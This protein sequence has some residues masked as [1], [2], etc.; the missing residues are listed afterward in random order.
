MHRAIENERKFSDKEIFDAILG[1]LFGAFETTSYA[2]IAI[3]YRLRQN[4][5][6]EEK[7]KQELFKVVLEN[8]KRIASDL[9]LIHI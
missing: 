5:E 3:L 9:S 4:P 8:G 7:L 1:F 6:V 2:I